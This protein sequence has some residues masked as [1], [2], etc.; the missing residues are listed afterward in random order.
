MAEVWGRSGTVI[1]PLEKITPGK[2]SL[3]KAAHQSW[4]GRLE[5]RDV[6]VDDQ[7]LDRIART[8]GRQ[9]TQEER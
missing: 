7:L 9:L 1:E 8:A 3:V 5:R 2:E 4:I 6:T